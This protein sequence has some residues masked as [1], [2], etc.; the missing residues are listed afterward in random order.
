MIRHDA[1]KDTSQW[2]L[3]ERQIFCNEAKR[4]IDEKVESSSM[5][6]TGTETAILHADMA[7]VLRIRNFNHFKLLITNNE[8]KINYYQ[9]TNQHLLLT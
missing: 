5:Y 9:N 8:V 7:I 3:T 1:D 4:F 6:H 2:H